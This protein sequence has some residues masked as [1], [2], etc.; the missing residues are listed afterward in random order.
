MKKVFPL[1]LVALLV[2]TCKKQTSNTNPIVDKSTTAKASFATTEKAELVI[3]GMTCAV[4]CAGTIQKSLAKVEGVQSVEVDFDKRLA[5]VEFNPSKIELS[6]LENTVHNTADSYKV[7]L[8]KKV[9]SFTK[10]VENKEHT[11]C[12][13]DCTKDC[14]KD[15]KEKAEAPNVCAETC[16]KECCSDK[17]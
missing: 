13:K 17:L 9:D 11:K 16:T 6:D 1:M 7:V 12:A 14:C 4:G 2:F 3:N 15:K 5:M 8:A 10:A